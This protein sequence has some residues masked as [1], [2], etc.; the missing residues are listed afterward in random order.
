MLRLVLLFVIASS[1]AYFVAA[2]DVAAASI[3]ADGSVRPELDTAIQDDDEEQSNPHVAALIRS[4]PL[5]KFYINGTWM[6]PVV[7]VNAAPTFFDLI[8]P[9]TAR[10]AAQVALGS[11]NDVS[12]AVLAAKEAWPSWNYDTSPQERQRLVQRLIDV[13]TERMD[14]M[15]L[16]VSTE[17][18]SPI[19]AAR[20]SHV[21]GGRGNIRSALHMFT[22]EF[23][24]ERPLPNIYPDDGDEQLTTIVYEAV[25]VVGMITPWNW[26]LNQITLVSLERKVSVRTK[27]LPSPMFITQQVQM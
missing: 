25:G 15:G 27:I 23:E 4:L 8:D 3:E 17:M 21:A 20:S 14:D 10:V 9:S 2:N 18:G 1:T 5:D 6:D 22:E 24:L 26:P 13:Y 16:L 12:A 7:A 11:P 19:V